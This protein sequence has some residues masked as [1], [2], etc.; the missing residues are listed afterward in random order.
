MT[1]DP[2]TSVITFTSDDIDTCVPTFLTSVLPTVLGVHLG[3]TP[4]RLF[5]VRTASSRERLF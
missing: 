5:A 3:L 4:F 2:E 1:Y